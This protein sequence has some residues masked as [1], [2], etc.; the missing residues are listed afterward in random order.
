MRINARLD[1]ES[2]QQ[3]TYLM[4]ATGEGVSQVVR[5]AVSRYYRDVRTDRV[6]LRHFAQAVGQGDS[7]HA[8]IASNVKKYYAEALAAKYPQHF[9]PA[10]A[11]PT[12]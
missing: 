3:L 11:E 12:E 7:G 2:E 10:P 4:Q 6:G 5:E 8:D 1:D 9:P